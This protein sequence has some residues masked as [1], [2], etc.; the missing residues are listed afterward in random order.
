MHRDIKPS[1][2][3]LNT[4]GQ[5][6]IGDF[7]LSRSL[8]QADPSI[9][10]VLTNPIATPWYRS[11]EVLMGSTSYGTAV[12]VWSVGC[13]FGELLLRR[14][15]FPA[16]TDMDLSSMMWRMC[17]SPDHPSNRWRTSSELP[18]FQQLR[19][20]LPIQRNFVEQMQKA[21]RSSCFTHDALQLLDNMLTLNPDLRISANQCL[22]QEYF[23]CDPMPCDPSTLPTYPPSY[24]TTVPAEC[25]TDNIKNKRDP[26]V[27]FI[28][29]KRHKTQQLKA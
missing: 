5:V 9:K 21:S 26:N 20:I 4:Q 15:M 24:E 19:P 28:K 13:I 12:D 25:E 17:G 18:H 3:L 29:N 22:D 8:I 1:N 6:K 2:I 11:P 7:G 23:W 27:P 10:M 14:P 16:R